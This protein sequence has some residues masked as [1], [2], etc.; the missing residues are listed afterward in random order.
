MRLVAVDKLLS[1][2]SLSMA[3]VRYCHR[4]DFPFTPSE[5]NGSRGSSCYFKRTSLKKGAMETNLRRPQV[6]ALLKVQKYHQGLE[7]IPLHVV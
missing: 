1:R 5:S 6:Q 7:G 4:S 3:C 2:L